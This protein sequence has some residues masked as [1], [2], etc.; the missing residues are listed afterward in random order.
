MVY[1]KVIGHSVCHSMVLSTQNMPI[2]ICE[3]FFSFILCSEITINNQTHQ[4]KYNVSVMKS[5]Q[6]YFQF[7]LYPYGFSFVTLCSVETL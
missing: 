1:S 5:S 6:K 4:I 7:T 2:F 3:L